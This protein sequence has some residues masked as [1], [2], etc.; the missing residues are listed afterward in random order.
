MKSYHFAQQNRPFHLAQRN[1]CFEYAQILLRHPPDAVGL[2][3]LIA[4]AQDILRL[5]DAAERHA[6]FMT[7]VD[8]ATVKDQDLLFLIRLTRRS[9]TS[10]YAVLHHQECLRD[11]EGFLRR[12]MNVDTNKFEFS[13][14]HYHRRFLDLRKGLLF[15]LSHAEKPYKDHLTK[16]TAQMP[17]LERE[18]YKHAINSL[19]TELRAKYGENTVWNSTPLTNDLPIHPEV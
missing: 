8:A 5:L 9:V 12:F 13:A 19:K 18:R 16:T 11:E 14:V 10:I 3:D 15:L 1:L 7:Q 2:A 4:G 6:Y 17:R